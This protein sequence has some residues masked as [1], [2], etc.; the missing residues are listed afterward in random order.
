MIIFLLQ[1]LK[2]LVALQCDIVYEMAKASV[3]TKVSSVKV[4]QKEDAKEE[5]KGEQKGESKGETKGEPKG[6]PKGE[7]KGIKSAE[8]KT[9]D[10]AVEDSAEMSLEANEKMLL[11]DESEEDVEMKDERYVVPYCQLLRNCQ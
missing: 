4:P 2:S 6:E 7:T 11:E 3:P 1:W 5:V 9:V 8:I 10:K